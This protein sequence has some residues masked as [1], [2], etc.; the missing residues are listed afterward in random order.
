MVNGRVCVERLYPVGPQLSL[1]ERKTVAG[2]Y[3]LS[4]MVRAMPFE[5]L[6]TKFANGIAFAAGTPAAFVFCCIVIVVWAGNRTAVQPF[7][8]LA[9][10]H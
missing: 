6:L 8:H 5:K 10:H 2:H 3:I 9:A 4:L 1:G 7:R